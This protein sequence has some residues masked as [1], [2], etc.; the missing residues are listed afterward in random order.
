MVTTLGFTLLGE[1]LRDRLDPRVR[2]VARRGLQPGRAT[3]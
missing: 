1:A 3:H 2:D